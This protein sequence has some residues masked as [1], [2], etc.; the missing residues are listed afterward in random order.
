MISDYIKSKYDIV[1]IRMLYNNKEIFDDDEYPGIFHVFD[2]PNPDCIKLYTH[3][4]SIAF[5]DLQ[6]GATV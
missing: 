1:S 4:M 6:Q 3:C 5:K 2:P